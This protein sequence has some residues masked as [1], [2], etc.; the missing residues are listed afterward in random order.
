MESSVISPDKIT[1]TLV[2]NSFIEHYLNYMPVRDM[3]KEPLFVKR[4]NKSI[5]HDIL[6]TQTRVTPLLKKL[7]TGECG[8]VAVACGWVIS[9]LQPGKP[10]TYYDNRN[11]GYFSIDGSFYDSLVPFGLNSHQEMYGANNP[12]ELRGPLTLEEMCKEYLFCD[13]QGQEM[14]NT[15]CELWGVPGIC[16]DPFN[17]GYDEVSIASEKDFI[18]KLKTQS[19]KTINNGQ[20]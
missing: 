13:I 15:F 20:L 11:H 14:V 18:E 16:F 19:V 7:N 17:E 9:Q 1:P 6:F 2:V 4:D 8:V 5:A 12:V 10:V 3:A